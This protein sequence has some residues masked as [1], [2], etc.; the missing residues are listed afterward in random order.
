MS[1]TAI[2]RLGIAAAASTFAV[3]APA[4]AQQKT[5][6]EDTD[7]VK[8]LIEEAKI[9]IG[10][11]AQTPSPAQAATT[12]GP[13]VA[14]TADE[15]VARA[16]ERNVT[17]SQQRLTPQTFDYALAATYAFYRPNLNSTVSSQSAHDARP[18]DHRRRRQD[19]Q[20][21]CDLERRRRAE[22]AL[23]GWQL[24]GQLAEQP[25]RLEPE[26]QHLQPRLLGRIPGHLRSADSGQ[27]QD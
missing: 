13:K 3:A 22:P 10:Q 11:Q 20:R 4:A 5:A 14:L 8:R 27:P 6:A 9:R 19:Q 7:H 2:L 15:A 16:L 18:A 26:Q 1:K 24:P 12:T 21:H 23:A 17:L 25:H